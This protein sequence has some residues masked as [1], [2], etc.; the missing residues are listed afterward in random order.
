[1]TPQANNKPKPTTQVIVTPETKDN[2][3]EDE[4]N[5]VMELLAKWPKKEEPI[6]NAA[7]GETFDDLP[8]LD[9]L[10]VAAPPIIV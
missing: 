5:K 6:V 1:M 9:D 2:K 8:E 3:D 4:W 7:P 10:P